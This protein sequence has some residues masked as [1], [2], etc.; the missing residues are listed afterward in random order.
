MC[1]GSF[2]AL[3]LI[4]VLCEDKLLA[5]MQRYVALHLGT[6]VR[7]GG[8]RLCLGPPNMWQRLNLHL[9]TK[10]RGRGKA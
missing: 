1:K 6:Q 5:A 4:K 2:L 3:L 10:V 9:G 7:G 8:L